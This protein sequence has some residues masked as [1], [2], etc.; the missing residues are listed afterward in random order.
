MAGDKLL[1]DHWYFPTLEI[2]LFKANME[3]GDGTS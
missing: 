1:C 2:L 3:E